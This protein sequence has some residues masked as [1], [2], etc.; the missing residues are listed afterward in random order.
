MSWGRLDDGFYDHPK[1]LEVRKRGKD[2]RAAIGLWTLANAYC[3]RHDVGATGSRGRREGGGTLSHQACRSLGGTSREARMLVEAGLWHEVEGG[4]QF[5]DWDEYRKESNKLED[6]RRRDRERQ[7]RYRSRDANVTVSRDNPRARARAL[8]ARP[9]PV[10][11]LSNLEGGIRGAPTGAR[12]SSLATVPPP[13][14]DVQDFFEPRDTDPVPGRRCWALIE[15]LTAGAAGDWHGARR[16]CERVE[17]QARKLANGGD[18]TALMGTT[19]RAWVDRQ[20]ERN[21][22]LVAR[23]LADDFAEVS[24]LTQRTETAES[25]TRFRLLT[26]DER[27]ARGLPPMPPEVRARM[28]QRKEKS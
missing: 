15:Q 22:P 4:Y 24:Q 28:E 16:H 1:V 19:V 25:Q 10:P 17:T 20:R 12:A 8:P 2:G 14:E 13:T 21:R 9:D 23:Y 5:H 11:D 6:R 27:A 7:S 3:G 18:W 26:D